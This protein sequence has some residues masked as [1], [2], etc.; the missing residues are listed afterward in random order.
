MRKE[1]I[2]FV[3]NP[4]RWNNDMF[5]IGVLNLSAF[6]QEMG[7]NTGII[8]GKGTNI[9][10]IKYAFNIARKYELRTLAYRG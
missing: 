3:I 6:L 1:D 9:K 8:I 7:K 2:V 4:S 10:Q 5:S